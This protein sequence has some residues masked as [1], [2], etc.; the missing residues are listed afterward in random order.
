MV[1]KSG[2]FFITGVLNQIIQGRCH[3]KFTTTTKIKDFLK[4]CQIYQNKV[5]QEVVISQPSVKIGIYEKLRM[6]PISICMSKFT[7]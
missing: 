4:I 2:I 1:E 5:I 3:L 6:R 7:V